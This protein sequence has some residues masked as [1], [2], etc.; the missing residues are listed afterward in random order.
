LH[1]LD[2]SV[3]GVRRLLGPMA[4]EALERDE[5]T[6]ARRLLRGD[7]SPIATAVKAFM[8]REVVAASVLAEVLGGDLSSHGELVQVSGDEARAHLES[9]A[10]TMLAQ[11]VP[12]PRVASALDIGTGCGIQAF[13][14]AAHCGHVVASDVSSRCLTT[15]RFNAALNGFEVDLRQGRLFDPVACQQFDLI[16]SN[17]PFVI[18]SPPASRH[19]YRDFGEVGQSHSHGDAVCG[20]MVSAAET[21]LTRRGWCQILANWEITDAEDWAASPRQWLSDSSSD[22]WVI[23]RDV[24]DPTQ[25]VETWLR[26]AGEQHDVGYGERYDEWSRPLRDG[27]YSASALASSRSIDRAGRVHFDG[28]SMPPNY[29]S[30]RWEPRSSDGLPSR[31]S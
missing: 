25:Y 24:Q 16:V 5:V 18:G 13:H 20:R 17:P 9:A 10:S 29:G 7:G 4:S 22:V 2:Y 26:D 27:V 8:L 21:H 31:T 28:S 30:S 11:C 3:E 6:P 14:L 15:A 1:A 23:Q 19:D 12:R